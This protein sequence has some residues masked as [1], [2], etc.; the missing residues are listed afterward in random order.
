MDGRGG[1]DWLSI[2]YLLL[3]GLPVYLP[4]LMGAI[5]CGLGFIGSVWYLCWRLSLR[6][7]RR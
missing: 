7:D 2:C 4:G 3:V 1:A 5:A 6:L